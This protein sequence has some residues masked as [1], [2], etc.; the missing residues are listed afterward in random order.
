MERFNTVKMSIFLYLTYNL[1]ESQ[2]PKIISHEICQ[3]DSKIHPNQEMS[4]NTW[5]NFQKEKKR[6]PF[7]VLIIKKIRR[8]TEQNKIQKQDDVH[9]GI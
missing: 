5:E 7:K 9:M 2:S 6:A 8:S 1:V 3:V 4:K